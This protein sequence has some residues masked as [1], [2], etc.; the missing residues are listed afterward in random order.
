MTIHKAVMLILANVVRVNWWSR[1][2]EGDILETDGSCTR[3]GG[4]TAKADARL[5]PSR[6]PFFTREMLFEQRLEYMVSTITAVAKG[7]VAGAGF[8]KAMLPCLFYSK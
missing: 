3:A 1:F 7:V 2:A 5:T 6:H 8:A 4:R